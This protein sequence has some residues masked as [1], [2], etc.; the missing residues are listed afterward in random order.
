MQNLRKWSALICGVIL[1]YIVHE[2][3]HLILAL[4]FGSFQR[5]RIV[6]FGLGIQ[7]VADT[8]VMSSF[9]VLLF[10]LA[11]VTATLIPGYLLVW[12]R[13]ALLKVKSKFFRAVGYYTTLIFLM[14]DPIYLSILHF[15][16]GGG[17]MN[18]LTRFGIP[19]TGAS[20]V[21]FSIGVFNLF[22]SIKYVFADYKR[23]FSE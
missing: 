14:L 4:C 13:S 20:I 10:C 6:K 3:A 9:Q 1:Y 15:F 21:F 18:G 22:I 12:K 23:S 17:D 7:I 16:L 2:G 19:V 8:T 5:I 11:G